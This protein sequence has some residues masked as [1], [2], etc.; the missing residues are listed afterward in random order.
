MDRGSLV[1]LWSCPEPTRMPM[2]LQHLL[3]SGARRTTPFD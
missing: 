1:I 3:T 2:F